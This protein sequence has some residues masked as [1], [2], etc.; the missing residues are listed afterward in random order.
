VPG[1][2]AG[3]YA[4][5]ER[6][7]SMSWKDV[8]APAI[9]LAEQGFIVDAE[10]AESIADSRERLAMFEGS[11]ELFLPGGTPIAEGTRWRNPD[12]AATLRRIAEHGPAGFYEGETA[13]LIVAEMQ[14]GGGII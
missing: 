14:R 1:A 3:L 8:V 4:A 2:V 9:R 10:L 6:F 5:H 12:L 13:D 11:S 7:G